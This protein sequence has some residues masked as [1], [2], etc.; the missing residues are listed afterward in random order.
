VR[1]H[2]LVL[3]GELNQRTAHAL[4]AEIERLCDEQVS[5]IT[6][7]LRELERIDPTG[8]AVIAFRAGLCKRRGFEFHVIAG[9]AQINKAFE[10]AG[11]QALLGHEGRETPASPVHTS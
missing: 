1:R 10:R 7:D 4:E 3:T 6:L 8:V 11:V 9:P 2:T 5:E